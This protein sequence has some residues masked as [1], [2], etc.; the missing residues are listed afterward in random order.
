[1]FTNSIINE[2]WLKEFSL[3]PLNFNTKEIQN[4]VDIAQAIWL[5][6][7]IGYEWFAE[8][9]E[10][11]QTN[12]LSEE[13]STALVEA[14]YPY[15]SLAVVYEALPSLLYHVSEVSITKGH[16]D[17]SE[18]LTLKEITYYE[19]WIRRQLEARK[20]FLIKWLDDRKDYFPLYHPTS[21]GCNACS[22][23]RGVLHKPNPLFQV[24]TTRRRNTTL[25]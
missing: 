20:D 13:N 12:T 4:F 9:L 19:G 1:M 17:N 7:I 6:P 23:S 22:S 3:I 11:V 5:I 8:I 16:S 14:I 25:R 15:L 21:C 18:A 24:Y 2:K 10:Q